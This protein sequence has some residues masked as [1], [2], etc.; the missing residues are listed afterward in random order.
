MSCELAPG[1]PIGEGCGI[2]DKEGCAV[3]GQGWETKLETGGKGRG[4]GNKQ[5]G[6]SKAP[7]RQI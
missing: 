7:H 4:D 6:V 3:M 5:K 1:I 2:D